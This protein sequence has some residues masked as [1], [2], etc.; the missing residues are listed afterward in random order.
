MVN[1]IETSSKFSGHS[2]LHWSILTIFSAQKRE[3]E[4]QKYSSQQM[5]EEDSKI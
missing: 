4:V 3:G 5:L 2:M 1:F